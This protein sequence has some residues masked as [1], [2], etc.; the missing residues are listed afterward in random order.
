TGHRELTPVRLREAH[1]PSGGMDTREGQQ[2]CG[3]IEQD[4]Q[5]LQR[6]D[7]APKPIQQHQ[8]EV[9]KHT[10]GPASNRADST[11]TKIRQ[12]QS[13]REGMVRGRLFETPPAGAQNVRKPPIRSIGKPSSEDQEGAG[14]DDPRDASVDITTV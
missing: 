12:L 11:S 2:V 10:S 3:P 1:H 9:W 5:R 7:V 4:T 14:G 6:Q 13:R 8:E